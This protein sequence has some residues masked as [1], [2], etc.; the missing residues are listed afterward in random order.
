MGSVLEDVRQSV[1]SLARRPGFVVAVVASLALGIG[2]NGA[3]FSAMDSLLLRP[4]PVRDLDRTVYVYHADREH[5]DSGTSFPAFGRYRERT[6]VFGTVAA[7]A[8]ARPLSLASGSVR[9]EIYAELVTAGFFSIAA[10]HLHL[11]RPL[12]PEVDR[13]IDPPFVTVL[14]FGMW[15]QRFGRDPAIVG[16][17][18]SLNGRPFTV[19]GVAEPGFGGFDAEVSADLWIPLTSWAHLVGEPARLTSDEHWITTLA[20]L[21]D[22]VTLEQ[23]RAAMTIAGSIEAAPGRVTKVRPA[24]ERPQGAGAEALAIGGAASG[25]GLLVLL[26]ACTNVANLTMARAAARQHEMSVR[27]ALGGSPGRLLRLW[28]TESL[29]LAISAGGL[30]LVLAAWLVD[31][32]RAFKPPTFIG[33]SAAP[34]LALAFHLD[35]RIL[36]FTLGLSVLAGLIVGALSGRGKHFAPGC[37]ARSTVIALQMALSMLLLVPCGLLVRSWLK[38]PKIA[39]GF[40]SGNVLVLPISTHQAGI[41]VA[42]PERFEQQLVTRLASLPGVESVTVMDPVPLW[43]GG[44][45]SYFAPEGGGPTRIG[46]AV[47]GPSYFDTLRIPLLAGRDF[48]WIDDAS[49]PA[50][51]IVNET[52]ARRFWPDR[53]ALGQRMRSGDASIEVVGIAKEAKYRSFG[54]SAQPWIYLPLAQS[55]SDNASL[56]LALRTAGDPMLQSTAVEREVRALIPTWPAFQFRT[57]DEGIAL[58]RLVPRL[59]ATLLGALGAVGLLLAAIG[60]YGVMA[61]VARMRMR[62]I[63]IRLALGASPTGVLALVMKQGM[64]V[65]AVGAGVGLIA[66]LVASPFLGALLY[67]IHAIDPVTFTLV[68]LLLMSVALLACYV[69]TRHVAWIDPSE[70]LRYE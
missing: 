54:E 66:A 65:C 56:S 17:A 37:N 59:G 70:V 30:S 50:V 9:S 5:S 68:P 47:I 20:Q 53:N 14:S 63:G 51:A 44:S 19:V 25:V 35:L 38:A 34:T 18:V 15:Q 62:E 39:T 45:A 12:D 28:L 64:T 61:Y 58:Q 3:L 49:A 22:G 33:Q 31:L 32:G 11:G 36:S 41:A 8:G 52:L 10:V 1:R 40:S 67:E 55:P 26:L 21:A 57:L 23:A 27:R 69:A 4:L 60:V 2:V 46:L 43:Y 29:L 13:A 24:S 42:K 7:F 48:S 6:D 16:K